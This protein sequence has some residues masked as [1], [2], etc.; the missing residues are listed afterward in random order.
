MRMVPIHLGTAIDWKYPCGASC[1]SAK[2]VPIHLGTAIDWK[3]V[4]P[5]IHNQLPTSSYSLRDG[6]R[7]ETSEIHF[8]ITISLG[9]YSL[10][11]GDRLETPYP[12]ITSAQLEVPIHLGTAIDWK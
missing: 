11:D 6:D 1:I 5:R 9:S 3:L 4:S 8:V 10:R 2:K 12:L 7:L